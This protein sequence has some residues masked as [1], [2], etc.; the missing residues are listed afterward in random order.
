MLLRYFKRTLKS[1]IPSGENDDNAKS[2]REEYDLTNLKADLGK[3]NYISDYHSNI[4]DDV[5]RAYILKGLCQPNLVSFPY[6]KFGE[7]RQ[8][9]NRAW[10]LQYVNWFEYSEP[11]DATY[12]LYC[13]LF[14]VNTCD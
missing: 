11:K 13:Y 2:S 6:T 9:F 3:R 12:C 14:K 7:K 8:H 10:Y 5:R 4:L 1:S